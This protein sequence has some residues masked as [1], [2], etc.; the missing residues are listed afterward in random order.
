[1]AAD[2]ARV[3]RLLITLRFVEPT[4]WRRFM[5]LGGI[6][7]ADLHDMLQ[8]IM[9]WPDQHFHLFTTESGSYGTPDV[10]MPIAVLP[11]GSVCLSQIVPGV[12]RRLLYEYDF[13]DGWIHDLVA[14]GIRPA[15]PEQSLPTCLGGARACPPDGVGAI[16]GYG[17]FL[18]AIAHP[19][20][21]RHRSMLAWIGGGFDPGASD[22]NA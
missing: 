16:G 14:E 17:S 19:S 9:G 13:G 1:M 11:E 5:V 20:H 12:G 18:A 4:V 8:I 10:D 15:G 22:P 6:S 2:R 7:L 21:P 3:Y